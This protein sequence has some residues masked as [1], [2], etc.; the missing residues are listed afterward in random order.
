MKVLVVGGTG[1]SGPFIVKELR[2]RGHEAVIYHRSNCGNEFLPECEHV[3]GDRH[4]YERFEAQLRNIDAAAVIDM[5]SRIDADSRPVVG[6]FKGRI[7]ASVHI[8]SGDVY[9]DLGTDRLLSE[10]SP[11][12][13]EPP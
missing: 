1:L 4:D 13:E 3:H 12:R 7:Q 2:E 11:L 9:A 10:G 6:A 5:C 8:S